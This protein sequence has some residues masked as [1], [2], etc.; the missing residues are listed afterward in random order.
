MVRPSA[1]LPLIAVPALFSGA[2]LVT[3]AP[4]A[5]LR[6]SVAV[7]DPAREFRDQFDQALKLNSKSRMDEL[8]RTKEAL[9]INLILATAEG[10]SATPNETLLTRFEGLRESW[11]R[12]YDTKF[13]DKLERMFA[14]MN[15][16]TK[17][18]RLALKLKYE[19]LTRNVYEFQQQKNKAAIK[20]AAEQLLEM[21]DGFKK[22][23]DQWHEAQCLA[24]AAPSLDETYQGKDA[25]LDACADAYA[26]AIEVRKA[27]G[28][29]D[30]TYKGF[31]TRSKNLTG[32]GYGKAG[33]VKNGQP[34][35]AAATKGPQPA[36]D[37]VVASLEFEELK[38][39]KD[40]SRP[41]YYLDEH[42]QIW[43][44]VAL[45]APGSRSEIPRVTGAPVVIR[46]GAAQIVLDSDGDGK[47]DID[48]PTKGKFENLV[49][50][51]GSGDEKRKWA[52][53]TEVGRQEDF[54]QGQP[55]NLLATDGQY[56]V[57]Y[58]PGGCMK[59][60]VSGETIRLYDDNLDGV[61]GSGA[62]SWQHFGL[63]TGDAQM[64]FDSIRVGK[65]KKARPFSK[66]VDLGS[67]GWHE[68][69]AENKGTSLS[70]QPV[71]LT[72]GSVQLKGK[73]VKPEYYVL[74]GVDDSFKTTFIDVS[75][76]KKVD[77][78]AGRWELAFGMV[79]KGK[80]MQQMKAVIQPTEGMERILVKPGETTVIGYGSPYKF[81]FSFGTD[82]RNVTVDGKTV[83]ILG[84]GGEAYD[85]FYNCVPYVDVGVRR[86]G[87]KRA[88]A[89]MRMKPVVD[90]LG[91]EKHGWQG[92]WKPITDTVPLK[93]AEVEVQLV[94][95]KNKLFGK[96]E[97]D[98]K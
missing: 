74:R 44:A 10:V 7:Q 98:W 37:A 28:V 8:M 33:A 6:A 13:P 77:V 97:S 57:Y 72:T 81:D 55:M 95:K 90:N 71:T 60:T 84:S 65:E 3:S 73:G 23:G 49:L 43:P 85:R 18:Q 22:M 14:R 24:W 34:G 4:A 20:A 46:E 35:G 83:R 76:G 66:Y 68:V 53:L 50:E 63:V 40:L 5:T 17:R 64:E 92:M 93:G 27:I 25:D 88:N 82:G 58:I 39:L 51:L 70:A 96:V 52:V 9:A 79:R 21:A 26:R 1:L 56:L 29:K 36:G 15:A 38:P 87:G 86:K 12:V 42:R 31:T 91:L 75:G 19:E 59:G 45:K 48:W 67:A 30:A 62:S 69:K 78:P 32:L 94:E 2:A 16:G 89:N 54:Y 80:K 41:N 61:Y 47:G 11:K